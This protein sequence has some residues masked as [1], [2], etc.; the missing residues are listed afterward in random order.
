MSNDK[1][2]Q[3]DLRIPADCRAYLRSIKI[4]C[5]AVTEFTLE[6]GKV[7]SVDEMNDSQALQ[8]ANQLHEELFGG[9]ERCVDVHIRTGSN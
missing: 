6:S 2:T 9:G 7:I 5:K 4:D 1:V 8:Y 3:L